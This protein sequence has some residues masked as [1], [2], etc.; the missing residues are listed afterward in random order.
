MS[1]FQLTGIKLNKSFFAK[2]PQTRN[3][4]PIEKKKNI[5]K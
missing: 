1:S 4:K 2:S 3:Q 5:D